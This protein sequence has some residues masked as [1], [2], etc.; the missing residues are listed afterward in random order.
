MCIST[1][2]GIKEASKTN[3]M[4]FNRKILPLG[5]RGPVTPLTLKNACNARRY[6]AFRS[7]DIKREVHA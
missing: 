4:L 5:G 7:F 6:I 2:V 1:A 3:L